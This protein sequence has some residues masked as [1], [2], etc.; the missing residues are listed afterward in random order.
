MEAHFF[1][2]HLP[3]YQNL[4]PH[5]IIE[6]HDELKNFKIFKATKKIFTPDD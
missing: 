4:H 6:N 1:V 5:P 3:M 2:Q